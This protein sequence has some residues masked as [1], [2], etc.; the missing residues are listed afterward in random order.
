MKKSRLIW[1]CALLLLSIGMSS[2]SS[3]EDHYIAIDPDGIIDPLFSEELHSDL[4]NGCT[5][6]R[7]ETDR[8]VR[9]EYYTP[10]TDP[11]EKLDGC[12]SSFDEI[13]HLF[14]MSEGNEI[15]LESTYEW[16][17][18]NG[19]TEY[20]ETYQHYYK[21]VPLS[22]G[23]ASVFYFITPNGKRMIRANT[24]V[25]FDINDL[26]PTP[27][28]SEQQARQ[29]FANYLNM[30]KNDSW[31]C[32]LTIQEYSTRREDTIIRKHVLV[33]EM[34]GPQVSD[35]WFCGTMNIPYALI[36]A[37]TGHIIAASKYEFAE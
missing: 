37:H 10:G 13:K 14:P 1:M 4:V 23:S 35:L 2:C 8:I 21:G 25:L 7:D 32:R 11:A 33:Y 22:Y 17:N 5:I 27:T 36:D 3:D 26:N 34:T 24:G 12:P 31:P 30:D 29:I 6:T 28:I 15:R 16:Q 20:S 19:A 18:T 9:L